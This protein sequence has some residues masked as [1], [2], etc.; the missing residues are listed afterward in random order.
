MPI[1]KVASSP[2]LRVLACFE[3]SNRVTASSPPAVLGADITIHNSIHVKSAEYPRWCS[4]PPSTSK[5]YRRCPPEL[6]VMA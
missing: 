6:V 1:V 3:A 5:I 4:T 2:L